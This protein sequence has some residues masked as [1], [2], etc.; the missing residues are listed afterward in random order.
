MG[1]D[2]AGEDD[3]GLQVDDTRVCGQRGGVEQR[4]GLGDGDETVPEDVD[5]SVEEDVAG[6][7]YGD[8]DAVDVEGGG[9][10]GSHVGGKQ[11]KDSQ[12]VLN[13]RQRHDTGWYLHKVW[14]DS[15]GMLTFAHKWDGHDDQ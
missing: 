13:S 9:W 11:S 5:A 8:D 7:V 4:G 15:T 2:Q 6:L 3:A 12:G 1:I 14:L 10:G